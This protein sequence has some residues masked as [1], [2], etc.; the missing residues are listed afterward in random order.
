MIRKGGGYD[1]KPSVFEG[2]SKIDGQNG[3]ETGKSKSEGESE[4]ERSAADGDEGDSPRAGAGAGEAGDSV[5]V[6]V[7][8]YLGGNRCLGKGVGT[9]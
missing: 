2:E 5:V 8:L 6:N 9:R 7:C 4:G 1:P 3:G